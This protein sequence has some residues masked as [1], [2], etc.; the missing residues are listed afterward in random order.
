[1]AVYMRVAESILNF[2][3]RGANFNMT[4]NHLIWSHLLFSLGDNSEKKFLTRVFY[5]VSSHKNDF[6]DPGGQKGLF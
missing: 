5:I 2:P 4:L 6:H 3:R 1:M